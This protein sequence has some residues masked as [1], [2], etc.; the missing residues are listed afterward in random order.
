MAARM[1]AEARGDWEALSLGESAG[2]GSAVGDRFFFFE[3]ATRNRKN[4]GSPAGSITPT[5]H[6]L[7][8][9]TQQ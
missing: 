3:L 5:R 7:R 6:G 1:L 4:T 2:A 9:S 8:G